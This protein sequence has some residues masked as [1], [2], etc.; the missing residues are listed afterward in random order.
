MNFLFRLLSHLNSNAIKFNA[1]K[2]M[3][4]YIILWTIGIPKE[5]MVTKLMFSKPIN[6]QLSAPR[7]TK[8]KEILSNIFNLY[9]L[10]TPNLMYIMFIYMIEDKK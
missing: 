9:I 1:D 4:I 3:I 7:I 8:I 2:K 5:N 6:P 10:F